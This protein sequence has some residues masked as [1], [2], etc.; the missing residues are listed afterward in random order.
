MAAQYDLLTSA[1]KFY[2][3]KQLIC[4]FLSVFFLSNARA[5]VAIIPQPVDVKTDTG[6]FV[7]NPSSGISVSANDPDAKR[8][9][10]L[11]AAELSRATGFNLVV[12]TGGAMTRNVGNILLTLNSTPDNSIG[13]E[14]YRLKVTPVMVTVSANKPAGLF[15]GAQSF[16]QLLPKEIE[17]K[18]RVENIS[19]KAQSVDIMDYPRF[20]WRGL[21]FDV[22][23]HFFT[24][25][26]VKQFIDDMV[27]YKFN[28]LHLHLTDDQGWR[29]EIKSLP[30]L[31]EVGAW[32]V[33]KTGT[34]GTFSAPASEEPRDFGGF[35]TQDDIKELVQYAKD[36]FV[37]V[38]PEVDIPGHSLA[39]VASYPDLSCTPGTYK[40]NSGEKF[41]NWH[42]GGFTAMI[43][44]TLCPANEK[45]YT[46]LDKVF[47]EV[48]Q[49]F[50]FEYIH[51]GGD[52]CAK[53]FWE[54]NA[55]IKQ[56]MQKEKLKDMHEV[57]SYFV[58]RVEKIIKSKGKKMIGW[59]EI[60][61]GGLAPN[62]AVMS[63]RG[64]KGGI[65]AA[66]MGHEVVMSPT[67]FVYLD[68]MQSD[69]SIEPPVY[70][71]LRLKKTYEFDPVPEG[72]DPKF[73]KG[74][75]GNLWTEQIYN[76]RH[77]QYMTW[78]RSFAVSEAVW[79]PK[80]KRNWNEFAKRVEDHFN[81]FD[82][83]EKKYS[84]A[85]Y[86]P[87]VRTG[88]EGEKGV[89]VDLSTEVE[90]LDIYYSFDNSFPDNFY[91]KYSQTLI[92]PK[93][94]VKLKMITYRGK[95]K[96]GRDIT[97]PVTELKRRAGIKE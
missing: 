90:G 33:K 89:K 11:L 88:K 73:I 31:T 36:R 40:V 4:F 47:T 6:F 66:K 26:E 59:D 48:A 83:A 79:S 70:A 52:E 8:V 28:L 74:G 9:A 61:E 96:V 2:T 27:K 82:I 56:L 41:M 16:I 72:V 12:R 7:L 18:T 84:R 49:L 86:D 17:S 92:V 35:Y 76:M 69:A 39:A 87:I 64:V 97:I 22:V 94:A 60:L 29:I 20:G 78:P 44:N 10:D 71:T 80:E 81:R 67:T 57:Q 38:L 91:P 68:Y 42:S 50:P 19:W 63:W 1:Q 43:D 93:D 85:M 3:M 15:Y 30:K 53:N 77:A 46:F 62:A 95:E 45:V 32:N 55:Q 51:M 58:K 14:G 75:Q 24:K 25:A 21:M 5:Q 65:E 37:N 13:N 23:R 34:F 54:N